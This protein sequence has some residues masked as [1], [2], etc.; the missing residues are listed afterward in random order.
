MVGSDDAGLLSAVL[1]GAL[2]P[3]PW[4]N[5]LTLLRRQ[6]GA[7]TATLVFRP[8]NRPLGEALHLYSSEIGN[9][10]VRQIYSDHRMSSE[11]FPGSEMLEGRAYCY[12][13]LFPPGNERSDAWYRE[14][15]RPS[16][17]RGARV[18]R[19]TETTG[20]SAFLAISRR[21]ADFHDRDTALLEAVAPA[22]RGSL[23]YYLALERERFNAGV[24]GDAM[25]HLHFGW[26]S[27]DSEGRI[28]DCEPEAE[29][30]LKRS[31]ILSCGPSGRL[32]A[33]PAQL[34][35]EIHDAIRRMGRE[36]Q[37]RPQAITLN[38][39]P[40][41]DMLLVRT[42]RA[43]LSAEPR[44]TIVAYIH[45][46][47]WRSADRCAQLGQLFPLTPSESKLAL[48]LAQGRSLT[49][50]SLALGLSVETVRS[51]SKSIYSKTGAR[52]VA[53]LVRIVMRSVLAFAPER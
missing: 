18:I 37:S 1:D 39:D 33:R 40:W 24:S 5:F 7:G 8:P 4:A 48:A 29:S 27:L 15:V 41:L 53:D 17:V 49:E 23:R 47:S 43:R 34:E 36:P 11:V 30:V 3:S 12:E 13:Q 51:Y 28:V 26:M 10:R 45:G 20:V 16:G 38:Q 42:A 32:C 52:G 50:A 19:V 35:R 22:L 31:N 6:T 14:V 46:D 25:R 9:A 44:A 21:D 2:E